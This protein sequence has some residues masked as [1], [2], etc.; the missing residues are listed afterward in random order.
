MFAALIAFVMIDAWPALVLTPVWKEPPPI[1][2]VLK[3]TPN[4]IHRRTAAAR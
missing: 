1:Y 3:Y 2:D 4:V